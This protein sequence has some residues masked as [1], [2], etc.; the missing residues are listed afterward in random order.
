MNPLL[1][2]IG[3]LVFVIGIFKRE[4]LVQANS[5]RIILAITVALFLIGLVLHFAY[6]GLYPGSGAL[7]SPLVS[8][9]LYRLSRNIFMA[10]YEREPLDTWLNW[11]KGMGPDRIFNILYFVTAGCLWT[12]LAAFMS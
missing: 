12:L 1:F 6:S 8:L 4:L 2:C 11:S 10:T 5:F 7:L 9:V 3:G